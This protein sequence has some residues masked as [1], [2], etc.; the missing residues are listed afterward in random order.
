[1]RLKV[2]YEVVYILELKIVSIERISVTHIL[3]RLCI[4]LK[5]KVA[6]LNGPDSSDNEQECGWIFNYIANL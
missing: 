6:N 1:M 3:K 4:F 5:R 2:V